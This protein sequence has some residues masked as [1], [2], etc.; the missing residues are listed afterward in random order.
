MAEKRKTFSN[1][2]T[3]VRMNLKMLGAPLI[4]KTAPLKNVCIVNFFKIHFKYMTLLFIILCE[5]AKLLQVYPSTEFYFSH[6]QRC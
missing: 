3:L 4:R 6:P 1:E 5:T 2:I